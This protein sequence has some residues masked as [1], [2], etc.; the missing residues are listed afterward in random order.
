MSKIIQVTF[1]WVIFTLE[2]YAQLNLPVESFE[3]IEWKNLSPKWHVTEYDAGMLSDSCDGYNYFFN[4]DYDPRKIFIGNEFISTYYLRGKTT[5]PSGHYLVKRNLDTGEQ[6][7]SVREDHTMTNGRSNITRA[8]FLD[9]NSNIIH[10]GLAPLKSYHSGQSIFLSNLETNLSKKVIDLNSGETISSYF[11][12][13]LDTS[14]AV[15][16]QA[17]FKYGPY[18][19]LYKEGN[20]YR[21]IYPVKYNDKLDFKLVSQL[22][23]EEGRRVGSTD[24]I[25]FYEG[26]RFVN[27]TRINEDTFLYIESRKLTDSLIFN[28]VDKNL[29]TLKKISIQETFPINDMLLTAF[30]HEKLIFTSFDTKTDP[31]EPPVSQV[32]YDLNGNILLNARIDLEYH[33]IYPFPFY[34]KRTNELFEFTLYAKKVSTGNW[35]FSMNI[36]KLLQDSMILISAFKAEDPDRFVYVNGIDELPGGD[37]LLEIQE[38]NMIWKENKYQQD[39]NARAMSNMRVSPEALGL[40]P[41]STHTEFSIDQLNLYPNPSSGSVRIV[42]PNGINEGKLDIYNASGT[43]V[44]SRDF[45]KHLSNFFEFED[46]PSGMYMI[47]AID[48]AGKSVVGKLVVV[49]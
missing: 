19:H 13:N 46:L 42:F 6:I 9:E 30:Q 14:L 18:N 43:L 44:M 47:K 10:I 20:N 48:K 15:L 24:S 45:D 41:V 21:C 28:F 8:L 36:Y 39:G 2:C 49:E 37:I 33:Q 5:R 7:W 23:D 22:V 31:F 34:Y 17:V 29:K 1:L 38:N 11:P 16:P 25:P 12:D 35:D 3:Q 40:I 26:E 32:V 27:F 4:L